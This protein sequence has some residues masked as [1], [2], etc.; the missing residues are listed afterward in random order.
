MWLWPRTERFPLNIWWWDVGDHPRDSAIAIG[1]GLV[2]LGYLALA[3]V[4]FVRRRVPLQAV[5]LATIVLRCIL[6][7]TMENPEQRYTMMMFP[8]VFLAAGCALAG[9]TELNS[10]H[11]VHGD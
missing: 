2:N 3:V 11:V 7:A 6:L 10:F 8:I 5:L 9:R 1:L 4:G